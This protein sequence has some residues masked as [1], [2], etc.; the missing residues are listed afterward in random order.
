MSSA[1]TNGHAPSE[2]RWEPETPFLSDVPSVALTESATAHSQVFA[3]Q[4]ESYSPFVAEYEDETGDG[5]PRAE[6]FA[7]LVSELSDTEFSEALEDL[8]NEATA[9]AEDRY[10]VTSEAAD[11]AMEQY[12]ADEAVRAY[13][14]PI[15]R[16][17]ETM[18]EGMA[19]QLAGVDLSSASG[20]EVESLMEQFA[21]PSHDLSPVAD[22]FIGGVLK[23]AK[24]LASKVTSLMPH[25]IIM[26]KIAKLVRPLLERVLKTAIKRLPVS[27]Q[28]IAHNLAK[29]FLGAALS[30]RSPIGEVNE[31][32]EL[33]SVDPVQLEE[34]FDSEIAGYVMDGEA[35][36]NE[37][38]V[39][40]ALSEDLLPQFNALRNLARARKRFAQRV[41]TV[42]PSEPVEPMV[43]EFVPAIMAALK[44]GVKIIGRPKVVSA[45]SGLVAQFIQKYVGAAQAKALARP[46]V[47][48]GLRL[49]GA[50]VAEESEE[51]AVGYALGAT[52]E[53]TISRLVQDAPE[54]AFED[55][56][57]LQSY[58]ME[59]FQQA[60]SAHF[61]DSHIKAELHESSKTSGVWVGLPR[62][63]AQKGY[64]KY[65]R[66][67]DLTVTPQ[68]ASAT[69]TFGGVSLRAFLSDR[70][71]IKVDG[72]IQARAH[73]FEAIPGTSL[74]LIA[75]GEKNVPLLGTV[76]RSGRSLIHPLTP[77]AATALFGEPRLARAV[78]QQFLTRR[79]R[80]TVGQRFY[81]LEVSGAR[82]R[83]LRRPTISG[84]RPARSSQPQIV[85]DFPKRELRLFLFF[86]E[87]DAQ[88]VAAQL[89]RK[90]SPTAVLSLLKSLHESIIKRGLATQSSSVVKVIHEAA[91]TENLAMPLASNVMKLMGNTLA[92]K[93][94]DWLVSVLSKELTQNYDKVA[95]DFI[96]AASNDADGVTLRI[97]FQA[98]P[99]L[100]QIRR[101][102]KGSLPAVPIT[103]G[104]FGK[105]TLGSYTFEMRP[106]YGVK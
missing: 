71:G 75:R 63:S 105:T 16:V 93:V 39:E 100:E 64:K 53:D 79:G 66:V 41:V 9:I 70:L 78:D 106:G 81:F 49:V 43:E 17:T 8:V 2:V 87:A 102:L 97:T 20:N 58:A 95:G 52:V 3:A 40:R 18:L 91:P 60:A 85:L 19:E 14:E 72:P 31:A 80:I 4:S 76:G 101:A 56:A 29:R 84:M 103:V 62:G 23:K 92:G 30:G 68:T 67:M 28:P 21:V 86:S 48:A 24:K 57:L 55:E 10:R 50:E 47:D 27:V 1:A 90:T 12:G 59:A 51:E 13:L 77:E 38:A 88:Q 83:Q 104:A 33:A 61:P 25:A 96:G 65:S 11:E 89:R 44:L 74:G 37:A 34:E 6:Q 32:G 73:L 26:K 35:F 98:P 45:L 7:A 42:K 54:A 22:Q 82:L 46:L 5:G 94:R 15:A 99:I 36:E 69:T